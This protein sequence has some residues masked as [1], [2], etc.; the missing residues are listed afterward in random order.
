MNNETRTTVGIVF[1]DSS[2]KSQTYTI[3]PIITRAEIWNMSLVIRIF[4]SLQITLFLLPIYPFSLLSTL[5]TTS[6]KD[7]GTEVL[8]ISIHQSSS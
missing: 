5:Y 8:V 2:M 1:S 4:I 3:N 6:T 7:L